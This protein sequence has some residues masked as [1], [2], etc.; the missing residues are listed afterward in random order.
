MRIRINGEM[1]EVPDNSSVEDVLNSRRVK[2]AVIIELNGEIVKRE[3][4]ASSRLNSDDNL[5]LVR[6][7]GG[8]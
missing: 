5:E 6:M 3:N 7:I 1:E 8:G 4:W 2:G